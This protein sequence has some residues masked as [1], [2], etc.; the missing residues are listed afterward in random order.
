MLK[1]LMGLFGG[2]KPKRNQINVI[3]PYKWNGMWVFDDP[4]VGLDK[5]GLVGGMPEIIELACRQLGVSNPHNGFLC[6]FSKDKFPDAKL[7]LEWVREEDGGNVYRWPEMN[8][9][10]WLCPALFK[11]F[12]V[13]PDK[14]YV[15]AR[16]AT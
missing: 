10:G 2:R 5:E 3:K 12:E 9:E 13:R 16:S 6:V 7:C 4:A 11:Y 14:L 8:M 1:F 15:D